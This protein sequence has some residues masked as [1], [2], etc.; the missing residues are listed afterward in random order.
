MRA[1]IG[2][3]DLPCSG[4]LLPPPP[5]RATCPP[6]PNF[7]HAQACLEWMDSWVQTDGHLTDQSSG[8]IWCA[9]YALAQ[10]AAK[11]DDSFVAHMYRGTDSGSPG[12]RGGSWPA[13][14]AA[15]VV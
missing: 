6:A 7:L 4:C 8:H 5:C 11:P 9:A 14:G 1:C 10:Y 15:L 13:A 2:R 12:C 3:T